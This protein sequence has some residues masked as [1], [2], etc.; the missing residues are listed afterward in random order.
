MSNTLATADYLAK[1][2]YADGLD[3]DALVDGNVLLSYVKHNTD[4]TLVGSNKT[5][6]IPVPY[7]NPQGM[8][9][10]NATAATNKGTKV[11]TF[12]LVP[13]RRM[14]HYGEFNTDL[15]RNTEAAGSSAQF[16]NAFQDEIDGA[17]NNFGQEINHR[18]YGSVKGYRAKVHPTTAPSTTTL[19]LANPEDVVFF[20]PGMYVQAVDPG[21]GTLRASTKIQITKVNMS[22]GTITG[23]AN[24]STISGIAVG[25]WLIRADFLDASIDGLD[26]WVPVTASASFLSVDQTVFRERLAGVYYDGSTQSI[27]QA[28]I[29]FKAVCD[30]QIGMKFKGSKAPIFMNPADLAQIVS[31]VEA[32]RTVTDATVNNFGVGIAGVEILGHTVIADRSCPLGTCYQIPKES[33]VFATAGNQPKLDKGGSASA[34]HFDPATG[35]TNYVFALDGN[36][37]VP[38]VNTV[39][40]MTLPTRLA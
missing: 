36:F 12:F 33:C 22:L 2:L 39:A 18:L 31:A 7:A 3:K 6:T 15:L 10:T 26:G 13:Q 20:E 8:G 32:V 5:L 37:I 29:R 23:S 40:R 28:F 19:T 34:F 35:V 17:T 27:R 11:G 9:P 24:W 30:A 38:K 25:D 1:Q 14:F 16:V 21:T 4:F